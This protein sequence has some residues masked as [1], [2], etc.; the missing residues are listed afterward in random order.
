MRYVAV[1]LT[2]LSLLLVCSCRSA[3][4]RAPDP[5]ARTRHITLP[6]AEGGAAVDPASA[7]LSL[8]ARRDL[9]FDGQRR[10]LD[11]VEILRPVRHEGGL[12]FLANDAPVVIEA[13]RSLPVARILPLIN[14]LICTEHVNIGFLAV[15]SDGPRTMTLPVPV[16]HGCDTVLVYHGRTFLSDH[17]TQDRH[18][19]ID[20]QVGR[21]GE[22]QVRDVREGLENEFYTPGPQGPGAR[23][24][25]LAKGTPPLGPWGPDALRD[26]MK[27]HQA[28]GAPPFVR[29]TVRNGDNVEDLVKCLGVLEVAAGGRVTTV[30]PATLD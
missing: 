25:A 15:T 3:R 26:F 18:L 2:F 5:L 4:H 24:R 22:F 16:A 1:A 23:P 11:Q 14:R 30:I 28:D 27:A 17:P 20:A 9:F 19:W 8:D 21:G 7:V 12:P 10:T 13:D 6:L 29:L